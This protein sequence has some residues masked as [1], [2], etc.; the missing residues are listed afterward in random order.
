MIDT[1][2][3]NPYMRVLKGT[4][5]KTRGSY[6]VAEDGYLMRSPKGMKGVIASGDIIEVTSY[7]YL[8]NSGGYACLE[9]RDCFRG[10]RY[11]I[12]LERFEFLQLD[13]T[14]DQRIYA[15]TQDDKFPMSNRNQV[16]LG[17]YPPDRTSWGLMADHTQMMSFRYT[18]ADAIAD[19]LSRAW[20][21]HHLP[22]LSMGIATINPFERRIETIVT[23]SDLDLDLSWL[24]CIRRNVN[25]ID[26]F[27]LGLTRVVLE[28]VVSE[29]IKGNGSRHIVIGASIP[30]EADIYGDLGIDPSTV[31]YHRYV[32]MFERRED[33]F[34]CAMTGKHAMM[35]SLDD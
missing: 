3:I 15:C 29:T 22:D 25:L 12:H 9:V 14:S 8:N 18:R 27:V 10:Y 35:L 26:N 31:T 13:R 28:Q 34:V 4:R 6:I 21:S 20:H 23:L 30:K 24:D 16:F 1:M 5:W 7:P 33:A 32:A 2:L 11:Y 19:F 17:L